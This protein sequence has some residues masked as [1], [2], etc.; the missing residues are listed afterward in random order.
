VPYKWDK[1]T[2]SIA[3]ISA[4]LF[5]Q[6]GNPT[7]SVAISDGSKRVSYKKSMIPIQCSRCGNSYSISPNLLLSMKDDRGYACG[8]CGTLS[9]GEL[10]EKIR[11]DRLTSGRNALIEMGIDPDEEDEEER[12]QT[13]Q[14]IL[15]LNMA[16]AMLEESQDLVTEAEISQE[17]T[18]AHAAPVQSPAQAK[19]VQAQPAKTQSPHPKSESVKLVAAE[20]ASFK[21]PIQNDSVIVEEKKENEDKD[22]Q[23]VPILEDDDFVGLDEG[24][25][26]ESFAN[27]EDDGF[28]TT[29]GLT[30]IDDFGD[31][32]SEDSTSGEDEDDP[33]EEEEGITENDEV[34]LSD[35]IND[36]EPEQSIEEKEEADD[37]TP[38]AEEEILYLNNKKYTEESLSKRYKTI[39]DSLI[40]RLGLIPY[41]NIEYNNGILKVK[42]K[43]C[44]KTFEVNDIETL[45][46]DV[47][48]FNKE[49]C[50]KYGLK[51]KGPLTISACPHC[52][53][54]ILTNGFNEFY[55]KKVEKTVAKNKLNIVKPESY[56][57]ASP[58]ASYMLEANGVTQRLSYID[59]C[60]KY[61]GLDM[62]KHE[63]FTPRGDGTKSEATPVDNGQENGNNGFFRLPEHDAK[64]QFHFDAAE[65]SQDPLY[66]RQREQAKSQMV[67]HPS[68]KYKENTTNIAVL[69]GMEN[70]FERE[71][72]LD[73]VFKKSA[74]YE[75][76]KELADECQVRFR[77]QINQK[78]FEIPVVD[79]EP[80]EIGKGG[81][82]LICADYNRN[83]MFN[84]PFHK[85]ADSIPFQFNIDVNKDKNKYIYS[86]LYSDSLE[87]RQ[88][89]AFN[90]LIKYIN[91]TMLAYGGKRIQLEGNL[92]IQYTDYPD[93]LNEFY[94]KYSPCPDGKPK[95]GELGIL[96]SWSSSKAFDAKDMLETLASLESNYGQKSNLN[97]LETDFGLYMVASIR[98]I[99]R[100]NKDT[101]KMLYTITEYV[102]I[103]GALIADGFAQCLRALLKEYYL[104]YPEMRDRSPYIIV[105][106]D[107]N[108]YTSP[109]LKYYIK[110]NTIVPM[111]K[112]FKSQLLT[113]K[114]QERMGFNQNRVEQYLRYVYTQKKEFRPKGVECIRKDIRKFSAKSLS[115]IMEDEIRTAGLQT[116][117]FD[118]VQRLI[119]LQNMGY[120]YATQLEI[121]EYFVHQGT[122]Q[123]ILLDGQTLLMSKAV[124]PDS[125]FNNG[126]IVDSSNNSIATINNPMYNP[127]FRAKMDKI[128]YGDVTP[129]AAEFYKSYMI[130]KQRDAQNDNMYS[131][132]AAGFGGVWQNAPQS[133]VDQSMTLGAYIMPN[134]PGMNKA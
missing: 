2:I 114:E 77:Y 82:R 20:I 113:K 93:Y 57:Y 119:F 109:S 118:D 39:Q 21:E 104:K 45:S 28:P 85:I 99:E 80:Y 133:Q 129:E 91:P 37:D 16:R 75:F 46:D 74:F 96:A 89:A 131:R 67:F 7:I 78:T 11:I 95:N 31:W 81:F 34:E 132:Q 19:E 38:E 17:S 106:L 3:E 22:I 14:E 83:S 123:H 120:V 97:K 102:E 90:A 40:K 54:S 58:L 68:D 70:P 125:M 6:Y 130:Q 43:I 108:N 13:E 127:L 128:R 88:E 48:T 107:S 36:I 134:M 9:D 53:H 26:E 4:I 116:D 42:C 86:V 115:K 24:E 51:F 30:D 32:E 56:W 33:E 92:N 84:V 117:I 60:N 35:I 94:E 112:I 5:D 49:D 79:F 98:Y 50:I 105:E 126:G 121:K 76:I 111:D 110:R 101:G 59:L 124:D 72:K 1:E 15:E 65:T 87:F 55:R 73:A 62:S 52:R 44:D 10:Q 66:E 64:H 29:D 23:Q 12:K 41:G 47:F 8:Q 27:F 25:S 71:E 122:V 100:L 69:S 103:G 63:L 61:D 18:Q